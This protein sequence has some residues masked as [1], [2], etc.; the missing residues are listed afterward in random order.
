MNISDWRFSGQRL[1]KIR[2]RSKLS[3]LGLAKKIDFLVGPEAIARYETEHITP[4][5][6]VA[7]RMADALG[8]SVE[9]FHDAKG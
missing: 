1:R 5:V 3:R 6:D 4:R 9:D 7:I 8:V 2:E